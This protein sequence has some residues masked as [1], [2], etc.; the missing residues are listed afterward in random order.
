MD[1]LNKTSCLNTAIRL[2]A[3]VTTLLLVVACAP[4]QATDSTSSGDPR[5]RHLRIVWTE[6]PARHAIVSWTTL[7]PTTENTIFYDTESRPADAGAYRFQAEAE[8]NGAI[9]MIKMDR[10]E[11]VPPGWYHHGQIEGLEPSTRIYLRVRSDGILS[12]EFY[13]ITAHVGEKPF[14]LLSGGDSRMGGEKPRYAG[15]TPHVDRQAMNQRMVQ[16]LE[17][18]PDILAIAHGAD[19]CTTAE[20]RHLYWWFE[21]NEIVKGSDNR[22]LPFIVSRGNHDESIG[23]PENFWLADI[24]DG[25]SFGYYY[26]TLLGDT[27]LITLNTEISVAGDQREWLEEELERLMTEVEPRPRWFLAQYHRPAYPVA[28]PYDR[29]HFRR[30]R[31]AWTPLFDQYNLDLVLESDG[32]VLKRTVPIRNFQPSPDG[33]VY[34]GEGGLGVPQRIPI[35]DLWFVEEPGMAASAHHVWLLSISPESLRMQAIGV[36]GKVLDEHTLFPRQ[37]P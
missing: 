4:E 16:L 6:N 26:S 28:K 27:A 3:F 24:T 20:W 12:E 5:P 23:F 17:E 2:S 25:F 33:V 34:I 8:R 11:G 13:F 9:T 29:H 10:T 32:H 22:L 30:V 15:R 19:W 18:Q 31:E 37:R 14:K 7:A 35:P 36:D 1:I 21:D